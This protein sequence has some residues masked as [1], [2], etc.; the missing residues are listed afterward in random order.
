MKFL[1][2][3]TLLISTNAFAEMTC[4]AEQ[5]VNENNQTIEKAIDLTPH[6][7]ANE[8]IVLRGELENIYFSVR[9]PSSTND[10]VLVIISEGPN[11]THGTT[12][13]AGFTHNNLLRVTIVFQSIVYT[14][15]CSK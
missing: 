9:Q 1:F 10:D 15:K 14:L 5:K 2:I 4:K 7:Y 8:S 3:L 13:K 11:Y 6:V 12:V